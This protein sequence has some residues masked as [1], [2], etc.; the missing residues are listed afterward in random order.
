MSNEQ[1]MPPDL[2]DV[3]EIWRNEIFATI[4]CIQIGKIEKVNTDQTVEIALQIKR[5]TP[6][7]ITSYPVLVDCPYFVLQGGGAYLDL[8]IKIGDYCIVLFNDRNIDTWWSSKNVKEPPTKRKHSLSDGIALVGINP[9][10]AGDFLESDGSIV[11]L[12][13][14]SGAGS[15]KFAA[16]K[17]DPVTVTIPANT[18]IVSVSGGSGAPAV[19][20]L[21][22]A[23]IDVDGIITDGSS[24]VK[25]G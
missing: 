8:P 15:E 12:L 20:V 1:I 19:G 25:I 7:G 14:T 3:L 23:P 18:F 21:N 22:P 6:K 11:R 2:D 16:R 9:G 5:R 10:T 4:N 17:D 24:E 13:G